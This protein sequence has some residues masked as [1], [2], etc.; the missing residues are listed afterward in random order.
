MIGLTQCDS[1]T[2]GLNASKVIQAQELIIK[3]EEGKTRA[4]LTEKGLI[5][6]DNSGKNEIQLMFK[7]GASASLDFF[8][9]ETNYY[10]MSLLPGRL[11]LRGED[12][13]VINLVTG[14][15]PSKMNPDP[16]PAYLS[17]SSKDNSS[18]D[19]NTASLNFF[20]NG[21]QRVSLAVDIKDTFYNTK[22]G[23]LIHVPRGNVA[24]LTLR[25]DDGNTRLSLGGGGI[26]TIK[27]GAVEQRPESSMVMF[28]RD[29]KVIWKVPDLVQ[30][31]ARIGTS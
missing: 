17:I 16:G 1:V 7:T 5:L 19:L 22:E 26:K 31:S 29:E 20:K 9:T 2:R 21:N 23:R 3:D 6:T 30:V 27:T 15:A 28:D 12:E 14:R 10:S 4:H 25:D 8:N 11:F 18:A 24:S 13:S